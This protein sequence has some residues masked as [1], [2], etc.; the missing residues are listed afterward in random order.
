MSIA[1]AAD[2]GRQPMPSASQRSRGSLC[3]LPASP[4]CAAPTLAALAADKGNAA[5]DPAPLLSA[6]HDTGAAP[7]AD[8]A[9]AQVVS[10]KLTE[11]ATKAASKR[12]SPT[13]SENVAAVQAA[14][15]VVEA[16]SEVS[17]HSAAAPP[18]RQM[19]LKKTQPVAFLPTHQH[20]PQHKNQTTVLAC[21]GCCR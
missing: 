18:A 20:P 21:T 17:A 19:Y 16:D 7:S 15:P 6:A 5:P 8:A 14:A 10:A 11:V 4:Q 3:S 2:A 13:T 12:S 1:R 9:A